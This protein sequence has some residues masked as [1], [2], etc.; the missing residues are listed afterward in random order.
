MV[1]NFFSNALSY[2]DFSECMKYHVCRH[3]VNLKPQINTIQSVENVQG[4]QVI[5]KCY[6]LTVSVIALL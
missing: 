4:Y 6:S 5:L 3:T 2:F 1:Y